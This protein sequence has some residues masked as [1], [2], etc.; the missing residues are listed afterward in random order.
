M[1]CSALFSSKRVKIIGIF[2]FISR[3]NFM[4]E[5]LSIKKVFKTAGS[6]PLMFFLW[7]QSV[8]SCAML[9]AK[10]Q[11]RLHCWQASLNPCL[12]HLNGAT[13]SNHFWETR[14]KWKLHVPVKER[15]WPQWE[16]VYWLKNSCLWCE[17]P[18]LGWKKYF[19]CKSFHCPLYNL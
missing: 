15:I 6:G 12:F 10:F 18:I 1:S 13:K 11:I 5:E 16:Q 3:I 2:V 19:F 7:Y 17:R 9:K 8:W 14:N 4:L